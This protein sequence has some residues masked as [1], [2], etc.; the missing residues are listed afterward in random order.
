MQHNLN[1][2]YKIVSLIVVIITK[3]GAEENT[4][5]QPTQI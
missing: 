4:W 5:N 2:W 1:V 3:D